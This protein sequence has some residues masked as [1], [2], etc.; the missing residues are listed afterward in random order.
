MTSDTA[1]GYRIC[2]RCVMDTVELQ[3]EFDEDGICN[4][5]RAYEDRVRNELFT[6]REAKD[7]LDKGVAR[8]KTD[9]AGK[10]YDC[11]IGLSGGVDS[12]AVAYHVKRLGLRP[13]AVH[14]DNGW[15]AE[16]A[17]GNVERTLDTLRIDLHTHVLDWEEFKDLQIAFL[18]AS[19][20]NAEIPT[21]H[22]IIALLY[23]MAA[24][25]GVRYILTGGNLATEGI[26]PASWGHNNRD[27]RHLV[28][29]HKRFGRLPL[30]TL[31]KMPLFRW[32]YY[33]FVKKIRYWPILNYLD[34]NKEQAKELLKKELG[35]RDYGLKHYESIYTRF[36]QSYIL[37]RKFNVDKRKAHFSTL[38]CA[39]TMTR[40]EALEEL[41]KDPYPADLMEED[42]Q[43]VVKKFGMT[44]R[45]RH[46]RLS[47][48]WWLFRATTF[49]TVSRRAT[50][51]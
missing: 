14:L 21:D 23:H 5:C 39:G 44:E 19:V 20:V 29:I 36:V 33:T 38:I 6:G 18:K 40:E 25:Y 15:D 48:P 8:I 34:Y 32:A 27:L 9:G 10:E 16:L 7:R 30:R 37:P 51:I 47:T 24:R 13:L 46:R 42:R 41:K 50:R 26:L 4:Y 2:E 28:A 43:Y 12:T 3:I 22:A 45:S 31:P 35:W 11:I 17:V 49:G 1:T